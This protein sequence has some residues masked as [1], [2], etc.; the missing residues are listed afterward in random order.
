M[1]SSDAILGSNGFYS[2]WS[3]PAFLAAQQKLDVHRIAF[4]HVPA[5]LWLDHYRC[6]GLKELQTQLQNAGIAVEVF[7]P[8]RYHYSLFAAA[9]TQQA[10]Y[11]YDYLRRCMDAA[12]ELNCTTVCLCPDGALEDSGN[13]TEALCSQL[14][15]LCD[16]ARKR[17]MTLCL[18]TVTPEAGAVLHTLSQLR[19]VLS[20]LPK[21]MAALDTV[22]V[23]LAGESIPQWFDALGERIRFVRFQD[24]RGSCGR[25]W[26]QGVFP[27]ETYATQLRQSGYTGPVSINGCTDRYQT[28]PAAADRS[29]RAAVLPLL[30]NREVCRPWE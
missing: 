18:Q 19:Q 7:H 13:C 1:L 20:A 11:T 12:V 24:G 26:G 16:D 2:H 3:P 30:N 9:G 27:C 6:A 25:I 23:S 29:N 8:G 22:P 4:H 28:N 17:S 15:A 10:Q 5:H 14:A 21:L